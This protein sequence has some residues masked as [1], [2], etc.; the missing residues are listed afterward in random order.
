MED[1]S[2]SFT[3]WLNAHPL[4]KEV[5]YVAKVLV[6]DSPK[7]DSAEASLLRASGVYSPVQSAVQ[8][9]P[10]PGGTHRRARYGWLAGLLHFSAVRCLL[11]VQAAARATRWAGWLAALLLQM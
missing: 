2:K 5:E 3:G 8:I 6:Q 4:A 1:R 11:A 10:Y 9:L 7:H